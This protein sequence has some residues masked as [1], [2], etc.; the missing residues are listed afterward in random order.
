MLVAFACRNPRIGYCQSLNFVAGALLLADLSER[1]A[2]FALCT[3]VE[4]VMPSDYYSQAPMRAPPNPDP[5]QALT[6]A[7]TQP[8]LML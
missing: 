1:D 3:L 8:R 5:G 4:D 2:F 6:N 7:Q